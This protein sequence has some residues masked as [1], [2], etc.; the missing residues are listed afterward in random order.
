MTYLC[1]RPIT[2]TDLNNLPLLY[3]VKVMRKM[4]FCFMDINSYHN[5]HILNQLDDC[6]KQ[7]N[8]QCSKTF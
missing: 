7:R 4:S 6:V 2:F 8:P 3:L 5:D 1:N